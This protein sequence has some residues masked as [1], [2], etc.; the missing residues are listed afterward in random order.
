[1]QSSFN[2]HD[3]LGLEQ[4]LSAAE[5]ELMLAARDFATAELAPI[6]RQAF[7]DEYFDPA[8][9]R[10][11]GQQG[12]L[13]L[14]HSYVGYGLI[15]REFERVDSGFRTLLSVVGGLV[16][17]AIQ[18]FGSEQQRQMYLPK[19]AAGECIASFAL[20]EPGHGS[21]PQNM[22]TRAERVKSGYRLTGEKYWIGLAD[23]ADVMVV[24]AKDE[25]ETVRGFLVECDRAQLRI[26]KISGKYALRVV[27]STHIYLD[28]VEIPE[29]NRLPDAVGLKSAFRCLNH[30]RYG[31]GWGA[32][33]AAQNCF[34]VA[35]DYILKRNN[36]AGKQLVQ[37]K[38][39]DMCSE[40]ALG[41][42]ACLR[43]GRLFDAGE[44][45]PEHISFIKRNSTHKAL[46]IARDARDILGGQGI[47]D[48]HPIIRHL[49]NLEAVAT[50]EGTTDIHSL[51]LGR[52]ITGVT[53]FGE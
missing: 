14:T 43:V 6:V 52:A 51:I 48:S 29:T 32:L 33:G 8:L 49:L 19:L 3:P 46:A 44:G 37:K 35:T 9:I 1:M 31:I 50:Y 4:Q 12:F 36:F 11:M 27:P 38:L 18:Y 30:A 47:L 41:L 42:Q 5:R 20:T 13:Q 7:N 15:A 40:I 39:A 24:W 23:I 10:R 16:A 26:E 22:Q 45:V 53:A 25:S 2:R 34:D 17:H 21:D 28:G